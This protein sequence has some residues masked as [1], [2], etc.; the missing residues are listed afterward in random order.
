MP[1]SPDARD[2]VSLGLLLG[3]KLAKKLF[4]SETYEQV[5]N[6]FDLTVKFK[7]FLIENSN[8]VRPIIVSRNEYRSIIDIINSHLGKILKDS[9][10]GDSQCASSDSCEC[11]KKY[12]ELRDTAFEKFFNYIKAKNDNYDAALKDAQEWLIA[13]YLQ[14]FTDFYIKMRKETEQEMRKDPTAIENF[15]RA[16]GNSQ[17]QENM[18]EAIDKYINTSLLYL[19][20]A[21]NKAKSDFIMSAE[22]EFRIHSYIGLDLQSY[23]L[24]PASNCNCTPKRPGEDACVSSCI[25]VRI[26]PIVLDLDGDGVET[27]NI[28]SGKVMFDFDGDGVKNGTG[29]VSPDDGFL[30]YDRNGDGIIN[31]GREMFGNHTERYNGQ[32]TCLDGYEALAQ[33]DSN[34]D[35]LVNHLDANWQ[36]FRVWRDLNQNGITDEGELFTLNELG[37]SSFEVGHSGENTEQNGNILQGEAVYYDISGEAHGFSDAWFVQSSFYTEYPDMEIPDHLRDLPVMNGSGNVRPILQACADNEALA[38]IYRQMSEA[39][40]HQNR[41]ALVESLLYTWADTS[42]MVASYDARARACGAQTIYHYN[43]PVSLGEWDRILHVVQSFNGRYLVDLPDFTGVTGHKCL[44]VDWTQ[45][46]V[47]S[48]L[49]AYNALKDF[50]YGAVAMQTHLSEYMNLV[51]KTIDP[52]T[53][54]VSYNFTALDYYFARELETG[55]PIKTLWNM[56]DFKQVAA[57]SLF[58][59]ANWETDEFVSKI[60]LSME[61]TPELQAVC[62]EYRL[63]VGGTAYFNPNGTAGRDIIYGSQNNDIINGGDGNDTLYGVGGDDLLYG[64]NGNDVLYGGEGDDQL[65]GG[66]GSDILYGGDGNDKLYGGGDDDILYGGAGSDHLEGGNGNDILYGGDGDDKLYGGDGDD[67]LD[68]GAGNDYLE[69]GKGSN[70]YVFGEGY[71]H[72]IVNG[73]DGNAASHNTIRLVGLGPDDVEFMTVGKKNGG[74]I[75]QDLIIRIKSTGETITALGGMSQYSYA[76]IRAVEFGD[77]TVWNRDEIFAAGFH[78][79]SADDEMYLC[80]PGKLYGEG[81]NDTLI[82]SAGNDMLF[83][84]DGDDKLYGGDGDDVLDGGAGNDYLEGGRGNNIYVFGEGYGHDIV[85][86][87]DGNAAS[88][89]TIRLVGLGP[90]DIEFMTVG[91]KNGGWIEQDLIIRIKS[92]GETITALGGMSQYSYAWIRAVEFGDGTV[93]NRDQIFAAGFHGTAEDDVM[94]LCSGGKLYGDEG[95]D[96]INGSA[97]NDM[98]FGG[99]GDDKLYGG[100]GDDVLDGGAGNDF[101]YGGKGNN[102]YVFGKGYGHDIVD[103]YDGNLG[104]HNTIRLVGLQPDDVEFSLV[105]KKEGGRIYQNLIIRIKSTGETITAINGMSEQSYAWIRAVEFGDGTVWNR[106]QIFAAGINGSDT[107]DYMALG[108]AGK[109]Y[110]FAGNDTLI[111]SSGN[112]ELYGGEGNDL[113]YGGSGD[114]ILFGGSGNDYLEGGQG[115]DILDGG[116]GN[117]ILDGGGGDDIYLFRAGDGQDLIKNS[118]GGNDLLKFEDINPMDLWFSKNGYDLVINLVGTTDSVTVYDWYYNSFYAVDTIEAGGLAI[119]QSQVNQ[120]VQAMAGIGAP[121]AADGQ[122]TDDQRDALAPVLGAYWQPTV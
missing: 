116:A 82:G 53:N 47:D 105:G 7:S 104:N 101:L 46:M 15:L 74:R 70:I 6:H 119:V 55:D 30:V 88:H 67:I 39:D 87:Y 29:W 37:I 28:D 102:V 31:D 49:N 72:D 69:G 96:T 58:Q 99:V 84:G 45:S 86:G 48:I 81:G 65:H 83:G 66:N 115:N 85:N 108:G 43:L 98:L 122:W 17:V 59:G 63:N 111:G 18:P 38:D 90:D 11:T 121:G 50:A 19:D 10:E 80:S 42:G 75:E 89:N 68:G 71:G 114:D 106:D 92:T 22:L 14:D 41:M 73:Y 1:V 103:A 113:L 100:E 9:C 64:G 2:A 25:R 77:G 32:G 61:M 118:S 3:E 12:D 109:L 16:N 78:G 95:N 23:P 20:N 79:S 27:T 51:I 26:S 54:E 110:G 112:D 24:P 13:E 62:E 8:K 56:L 91:K 44:A 40:G 35:G 97:G 117:D 33:E 36:H 52:D 107:D 4:G 94:Y 76:W 5:V 57:S 120:L 60:I 34:G 21:Y 93:W